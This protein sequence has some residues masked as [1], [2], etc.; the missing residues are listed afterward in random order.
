[1]KPI[2]ISRYSPAFA[3]LLLAAAA[4]AADETPAVGT[5]RT[6][7]VVSVS[8]AAGSTERDEKRVVYAPPPGWYVRSHT[9][10]CGKKTGMSSYTVSTVPAGWAYS[11]DEKVV[12]AGHASATA[13]V[14]TP[15]G[16][17]AGGKADAATATTAADHQATNSSHHVIVVDVTAKGA[18]FWRGGGAIDL[19]VTAE[20]VYLGKP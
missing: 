20:M 3:V 5:V 12:R 14:A 6:L 8:L 7:P 4:P 11:R 1:M 10:E 16:P 18:G 17:L 19:T 9:V 15:A 13:A 2:R